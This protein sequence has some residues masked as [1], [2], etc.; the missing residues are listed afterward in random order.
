MADENVYT[1][2]YDPDSEQ[3]NDSICN[4]LESIEDFDLAKGNKFTRQQE[5][6]AASKN[7]IEDSAKSS[8]N[9][10]YSSDDSQDY[11]AQVLPSFQFENALR[12]IDTEAVLKQMLKAR[13]SLRSCLGK[14]NTDVSRPIF[15]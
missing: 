5:Q 15:I 8:D 13:A 4:M 3:F 1:V 9:K 12:P 14:N 6:N 7:N 11:D 2:F 10:G